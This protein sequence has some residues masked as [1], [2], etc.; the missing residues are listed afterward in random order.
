VLGILV[1]A[2]MVASPSPALACSCAPAPPPDVALGES[3]AVFAGKVVET[4]IAGSDPFDDLIARIA[5][6]EVWKGDVAETVDV[7]TAQDGATCGV[8]FSAGDR[9]LV[10]A[11]ARDDGSLETYLCSRTVPLEY[12]DEGLDAAGEADVDLQA[13]GTS[14]DPAPGE[15]LLDGTPFWSSSSYWWLFGVGGVVAAVAAAAF[16][17]LRS[18]RA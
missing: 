17:R 8:W 14:R 3:A 18:V 10:Y 11:S 9:W 2:I 4:R 12:A 15:Q 5:V 16:L 13:L 7:S 6:D 1:L